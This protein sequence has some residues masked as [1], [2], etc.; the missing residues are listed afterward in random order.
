MTA[1]HERLFGFAL[2]HYA[3][4]QTDAAMQRL[5]ELLGDDP[6]H[7]PAHGLLALCLLRRKRLHAA[8]LEAGHAIALDPDSPFAHQAA[9]GVAMAQRRFSDAESHLQTAR[10]LDPESADIPAQLARLY[11]LWQRDAEARRHAKQALQL[12][13]DDPAVLALN[14]ELAL[15]RGDHRAATDLAR[16]ALELD[17][18]DVDAL[19]VLGH[20]ELAD[21][22]TDAAHQHALWALNIDP[23]SESALTLLS[24]VQARRSWLLG[25]W[26]RF[27]SLVAS[28]SRT[29]AVIILIGLYLLYRLASLWLEDTGHDGLVTLITVLWL[30]FCVYTWV[31]PSLFWRAIRKQMRE[32]RLQPGV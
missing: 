25:L 29:R 27:Q 21:A 13:P 3:H 31:A 30:G 22:H 4:G 15:A 20:C 7:G 16:Q 11:S 26:W 24:A 19:C 10:E 6:D 2:R 18:E 17:P 23:M 14:A 12:A 9:A 1:Q 8:Q 5:V 28:G 32:V